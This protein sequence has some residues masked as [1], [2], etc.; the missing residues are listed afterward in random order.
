MSE[1]P[2]ISDAEW[3]VMKILWNRSP[4]LSAEIVEALGKTHPWEPKTV[5]TLIT[6][7]VKKEAVGFEQKDRKYLY[8]PK[9][10]KEE[11]IK[12]EAKSFLVKFKDGMMRPL[13]TA[14]LRFIDQVFY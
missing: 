6:R 9:V 1:T 2:K 7:L 3:E 5:K 13:L 8:Y 11:C 4:A 14:F 10:S 12:T